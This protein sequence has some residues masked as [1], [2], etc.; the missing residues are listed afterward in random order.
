[1]KI[2][3]HN[4]VVI[5]LLVVVGCDKTVSVNEL[6]RRSGIWFLPDSNQPFSGIIKSKYPNGRTASNWMIEDGKVN[7]AQQYKPN[8]EKCQETHMY[9]GTGRI[10]VYDFD[11]GTKAQVMDY[12]NGREIKRKT[13]HKNGNLRSQ[14]Q[15][16]NGDIDGE[17]ISYTEDGSR[18]TKMQFTDGESTGPEIVYTDDGLFNGTTKINLPYMNTTKKI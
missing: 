5:H 11:G 10:I 14:I 15:Y 7:T 2:F 9:E 1:M 8:G 13:F 12:E 3:T 6:E 17:A 4:I 18:W 16:K